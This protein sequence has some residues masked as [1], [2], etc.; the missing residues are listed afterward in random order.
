MTASKK[1]KITK[2]PGKDVLIG[3]VFYGVHENYT[4]VLDGRKITAFLHWIGPADQHRED[5]WIRIEDRATGLYYEGMYCPHSRKGQVT[6]LKER[7]VWYRGYNGSTSTFT[8]LTADADGIARWKPDGK[9]VIE[10]VVD[11]DW[12]TLPD[13]ERGRVFSS[14]KASVAADREHRIKLTTSS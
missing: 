1:M 9:N 12:V 5:F 6:L 2:G 13:G 3:G 7:R 14:W 11:G 10:F 4:F 8:C